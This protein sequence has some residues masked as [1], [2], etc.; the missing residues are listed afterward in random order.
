MK[1]IKYLILAILSL[2]LLT[3]CIEVKT[4]VMINKDG[5]GYL[6]ETV[7]INN[8]YYDFFN[9]NFRSD[10]NNKKLY[11]E[12]DLKTYSK[13]LGKD[14]RFVEVED[15]NINDSKGFRVK[16]SFKN[17][18]TLRISDQS[19]FSQNADQNH[20]VPDNHNN[21]SYFEF[22]L[23]KGKT[24]KLSIVFPKNTEESTTQEE[25]VV[26]SEEDNN[27]PQYP[28]EDEYENFKSV[29]QN[30]KMSYTFTFNT[31]IKKTDALFFDKNHVIIYDINFDEVMSKENMKLISQLT[32]NPHDRETKDKL[33]KF[34]GLKI[35]NKDS[36]TVE[37]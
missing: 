19:I 14:V 3:A 30:I 13:D 31:E 10:K 5:S 33:L 2:F 27:I 21:N 11:N 37:F 25:E 22:K 36:I 16:Y 29:F 4:N 15:L 17:I 20:S 18:E 7:L 24:S 28:E 1:R 35:E 12:N 34:K 8:T 26:L 6:E 32:I 9:Q 23:D